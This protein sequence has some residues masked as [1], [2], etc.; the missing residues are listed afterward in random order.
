MLGDGTSLIAEII[1]AFETGAPL[2]EIPGLALPVNEDE[3]IRTAELTYMPA[4][5]ELP[6]PRRDLIDHLKHRYYY[7][8]HQPV[9]F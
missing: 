9:A 2:D 7:L 5:D 1:K 6:L 4:P 8:F 3:L